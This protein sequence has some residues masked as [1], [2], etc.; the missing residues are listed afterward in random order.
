MKRGKPPQAAQGFE[1]EWRDAITAVSDANRGLVTRAGG[2]DVVRGLDNADRSYRLGRVV[3]DATDRAKGGSASGE[4]DTF[5]P[6]QLQMASQASQRKFPG[7]NP[8]RELADQGQRVLP[9]RVPDSGT[10]GRAAT[11]GLGV[12]GLSALTGVGANDQ[13]MTYSMENPALAA[14]SLAALMLGGSRGG[15]R[16]INALLTERP[17]LIRKAFDELAQNRLYRAGGGIGGIFGSGAVPLAL[18]SQ[19]Q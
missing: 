3:E 17:D 13:G 11:A 2:N 9:S 14:G 1:Q 12:L 15:Q 8:L 5:T 10:T 19:G 4:V 16:A 18:N 6:S 7:A